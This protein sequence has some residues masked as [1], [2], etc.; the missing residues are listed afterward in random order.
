MDMRVWFL[1]VIADYTLILTA[2]WFILNWLGWGAALFLAAYMVLLIVT[3]YW[4]YE[5]RMAEQEE[6]E[7]EES[8]GYYQ[9][10]DGKWLYGTP[11]QYAMYLA[12]VQEEQQEKETEEKKE[13][14]PEDQQDLK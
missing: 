6:E 13:E 7:E 5:A 12:M 14:W 10:P 3:E 8:K 11:E 4:V 9:L 2:W 1:R